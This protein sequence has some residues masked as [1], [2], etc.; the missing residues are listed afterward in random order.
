MT[1]FFDDI[2]Q[3]SLP[4]LLHWLG[5]AS[6]EAIDQIFEEL[7][8]FTCVGIFIVTTTFYWSESSLVSSSDKLNMPQPGGP[9]TTGILLKDSNRS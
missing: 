5:T 7:V 8:I 2:V 6:G 3:G 1:P 4:F 9:V